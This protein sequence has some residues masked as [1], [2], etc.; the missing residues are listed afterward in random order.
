MTTSDKIALFN[1]IITLFNCMLTIALII[2]AY[3]Q[4]S[5]LKKI[6]NSQFLQN[7]MK[8]VFSKEAM[9]LISFIHTDCLHFDD[10]NKNPIF[11]ID[12]ERLLQLFPKREW[13][14]RSF[15]TSYEM[16]FILLNQ[17]DGIGGLADRHMITIEAAHQYFGW[18]FNVV[19]SNEAINAYFDW[20]R[21]VE[22]TS[23]VFSRLQKLNDKFKLTTF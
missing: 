11:S 19:C 10:N 22:R 14:G 6:Q 15:Y 21:D 18:Y 20:L 8:E 17:L 4:L 23:Y 13:I 7:V 12:K 16:D 5:E 3:I 2:V 1:C 9:E